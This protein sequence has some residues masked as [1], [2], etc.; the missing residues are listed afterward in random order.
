MT[1]QHQYYRGQRSRREIPK[2]MLT[3][4]KARVIHYL[5]EAKDFSAEIHQLAG[6]APQ[7]VLSL[8]KATGIKY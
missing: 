7:L 6:K 8:D 4:V 3:E 2:E 1:S 5:S